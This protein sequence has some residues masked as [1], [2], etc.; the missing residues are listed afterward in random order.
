MLAVLLLLIPTGF[1]MV[2]LTR[3]TSRRLIIALLV[4]TMIALPVLLGIP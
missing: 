3:S 4:A 1:V 2:L